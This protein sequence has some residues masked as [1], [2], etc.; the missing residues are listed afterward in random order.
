MKKRV[1]ATILVGLM[2]SSVMVGCG[3]VEKPAN[4]E[5]IHTEYN[6]DEEF[7]AFKR[8]QF[9]NVEDGTTNKG[10]QHY[11]AIKTQEMGDVYMNNLWYDNEAQMLCYTMSTFASDNHFFPLN[12]TVYE[13]I[14]TVH[15][16][17][18]DGV[19]VVRINDE[20]SYYLFGKA[21]DR[22]ISVNFV[23]M[24]EDDINKELE[25]FGCTNKITQWYE[26]QLEK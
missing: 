2:C 14:P 4:A 18:V 19:Q 5:E 24:T 22:E 25:N 7:N 1:L 12:Y 15:Y 6:H 3:K 11:V 26:F 17:M 16:A 8:E 9:L 20:N 10:Y 23:D 21:N 13:T